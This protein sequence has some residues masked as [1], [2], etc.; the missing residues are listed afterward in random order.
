MIRIQS[1]VLDETLNLCTLR[2]RKYFLNTQYLCHKPGNEEDYENQQSKNHNRSELHHH[3]THHQ[4]DLIHAFTVSMAR[5]WWLHAKLVVISNTVMYI[6]QWV[7]YCKTPIISFWTPRVR[8]CENS[9]HT[10]QHVIDHFKRGPVYCIRVP[11]LPSKGL[12]AFRTVFWKGWSPIIQKDFLHYHEVWHPR[13]W[14]LSSHQFPH[15][16][17]T[18]SLTGLYSQSQSG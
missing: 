15:Y 18:G 5:L 9:M 2:N 7:W 4:W 16:R 10:Q 6:T 14:R 8:S 11:T 3:T 17:N 12:V 13:K 1:V